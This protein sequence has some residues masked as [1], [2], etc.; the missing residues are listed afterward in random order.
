M[1]RINKATGAKIS[2][3]IAPA[4]HGFGYSQAENAQAGFAEDEQRDGQEELGEKDAA[5]AGSEPS[6][7][8]AGFGTAAL[9]SAV[10]V[11]RSG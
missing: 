10:R 3:K 11:K 1:T 6:Q 7:P 9:G 2:Q 8:D 5:Q 4:G